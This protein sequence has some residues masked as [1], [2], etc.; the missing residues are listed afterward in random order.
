VS[1]TAPTAQKDLARELPQPKLRT[2]RTG[3]GKLLTGGKPG[4]KGGSGRTPDEFKRWMQQFANSR[5]AEQGIKDILLEGK[6]SPLFLGALRHVTEHGYGKPKESVDHTS[7]G[8]PIAGI[9]WNVVRPEP[10]AEPNR[11]DAIL[12]HKANGN[13]SG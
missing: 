13:G 3:K 9:N 8:K 11:I 1:K 12:A 7:G 5:E 10:G 6:K 2:P 4:H